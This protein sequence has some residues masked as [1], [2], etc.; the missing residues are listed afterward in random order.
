M[1]EYRICENKYGYYKIQKCQK[2]I[3]ILGITFR[4]KWIDSCF[5]LR[6]TVQIKFRL[7]TEAQNKINEFI[8][9]DKEL[10][11]HNKMLNKEWTCT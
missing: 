11:E 5:N 4:K 9:Q 10:I 1:S 7:R 8:K 6:G 2:E 3:K